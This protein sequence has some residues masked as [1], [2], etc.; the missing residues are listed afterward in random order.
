MILMTITDARSK[1]DALIKERDYLE[2]QLSFSSGIINESKGQDIIEECTEEEDKAW[3]EKHRE[4]VRKYHQNKNKG[5]V[6]K[7]D[8]TDEE[9]WSRLEELEL[10]EELDNELVEANEKELD[11]SDKNEY[12]SFIIKEDDVTNIQN[13]PTNNT[14]DELSHITHNFPKQTSKID[15]LLQVID[16]QKI[17]EEKLTELKSRERVATK[18]ESDLLSRLD[19]MEQLEDLEDE[20]DR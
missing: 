17:L 5:E 19:E 18:T 14:Q 4:R 2:N 7:G 12:D 15:V 6:D 10:Q 20:M 11:A 3:R 13:E 9:L 16:R 8:V 1:L